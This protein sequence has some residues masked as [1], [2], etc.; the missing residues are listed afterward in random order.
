MSKIFKSIIPFA[1]FITASLA[2]ASSAPVCNTPSESKDATISPSSCIL[3]SNSI[4]LGYEIRSNIPGE[5]SM[6]SFTIGD[7]KHQ[8]GGV[9]YSIRFFIDA[10]SSDFREIQAFVQSGYATRSVFGVIYSNPNLSGTN[11]AIAEGYLMCPIQGI[12]IAH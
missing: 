2:F 1:V 5:F 11:C 4:V 10:S 12:S 7:I 8:V 6:F 3:S 9:N